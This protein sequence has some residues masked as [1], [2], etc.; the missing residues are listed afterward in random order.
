MKTKHFHNYFWWHH[1]IG[2][3]S[4]SSAWFFSVAA[5]AALCTCSM[6]KTRFCSYSSRGRWNFTGFF[7]PSASSNPCGRETRVRFC[8]VVVSTVITMPRLSNAERERAIGML[9]ANFSVRNVAIRLN[10]HHSTIVRLRQRIRATGRTADRPQP[11]LPRFTTQRQDTVAAL[12]QALE[13]EWTRMPQAFFQRL[14]QSMRSLC[15]ACFNAN[16]GHTRY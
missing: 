14:V 7:L 3:Q 6:R 4:Y 5:K 11:G 12:R 15:Q 9:Q 10:C 13:R 16:G 2:V 1:S 8:S